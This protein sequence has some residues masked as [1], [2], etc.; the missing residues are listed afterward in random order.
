MRYLFQA[1]PLLVLI[2]V[3]SSSVFAQTN[4]TSL[5][6]LVIDD[7]EAELIGE[8]TSSTSVRPY[9]GVSYIHDGATGKGEKTAKFT[10]RVPVAGDY[11]L[12]VAYT[13][14]GNRAKQVPITVASG[15]GKSTLM[16]DQTKAPALGTGF[17]PVGEFT[18]SDN[19]DATVL[20]ETV[21]TSQ[22]VIVDGIRLLSDSELKVAMKDEKSP[23]SPKVVKKEAKKT[24][25]KPKPKPPEFARRPSGSFRKITPSE[26]DRLLAGSDAGKL[27]LVDDVTFLRR[28][29]LD[30]TGRQPS[31]DEYRAF[32]ADKSAKR[33]NEAIERLLASESFGQNWG[34]YWSDVIAARQD[35]PQLTYLNYTPFRAWLARQFNEGTGWDKTVFRMI[36]AIGTV[37]D[38]PEGTFVGFHQG[39]RNKLAGE[40][41]RIF[42]GLKISCAQCHDHPFVD[43][44]QETFHGM[45]AFFARTKVKLPWNDSNGI[46]I[47]STDKGEHKMPGAKGEMAPTV[48]QGEA[49]DLG[50]SD[51]KR[52][53]NLAYWFVAG[54]NP[55]FARAFVNHI[56]ARLM[57]RGFYDPVD[58]LGEG[59]LPVNAEAHDAL[60]GHFVASGFD[61][62]SV[63]RLIASTRMYQSQRP[64][65]SGFSGATPKKLRGDEVF[66]SL[67]VAIELP[68][69]ETKVAAS[70]DK[71]RFPP[72]A[73]TT[74]DLVNEAFGFDP[75]VK[76]NLITRTMKQAI[77]MMNN[78]QLHKQI[79]ASPDSDTMLSRLLQ[80]EREDAIVIEVLYA[81]VLAR[82]PTEAERTIVLKHVKSIEDR[83]KAFEDVM[84]SLINSAEFT[85]RN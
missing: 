30:L 43:L 22:H 27:E 69:I 5:S 76:D 53:E 55:Y 45:A 84:W 17:Q 40:S 28:A 44:P 62:K 72:P 20:I 29:T 16:L 81:R 56:Q 80:S 6:G 66:D 3:V 82:R 32:L 77:F 36:T 63:F 38:G 24:N 10:F 52:R 23:R 11:Q 34:N 1:A 25:S 18:F 42:L 26:F 35:E 78:D 67:A 70:T 33:R 64:A 8:W 50:L 21:G 48:Y 2:L 41:A 7:K 61:V 73:K 9:L 65:T 31:L 47:S 49:F 37:G 85:T 13:H 59:A 46:E 39:E 79:N 14:G 57:G 58:D 12:L 19:A 68:N 4:S 74:R 60:A 15:D 54:D 51:L 75:S 71:T 83:G